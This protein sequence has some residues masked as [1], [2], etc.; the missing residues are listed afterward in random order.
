MW[1]QSEVRSALE[2][3]SIQVRD[4]SAFIT[5]SILTRLRFLSLRN[6]PQPKAATAR[7]HWRGCAGLVTSAACF[8]LNRGSHQ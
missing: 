4:V 5:A 7:L 8:P 2:Q 6:I 3:A 1:P